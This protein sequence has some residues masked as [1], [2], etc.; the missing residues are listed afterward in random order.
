MNP[1]ITT[2]CSIEENQAMVGTDVVFEQTLSDETDFLKALYKDLRV[3]YP[4]FY[5]MDNLSKLGFL[6]VELLK[7]KRPELM[8]KS[9]DAIAMVFQNQMSC[10]ESDVMHQEQVNRQSPSPAVFVYTLP[11]I[12]IGELSIRNK[13]YGESAFFIGKSRETD[14]LISY[15]KSLILTGK[16]EV[17]LVGNIESFGGEHKLRVVVVERE[18]HGEEFTAENLSRFLENKR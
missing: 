4:K 18:G 8:E 15:S 13:W 11:N 12:V 9:D 16:A 5:K 3:D 7:T 10:L 1:V 14:N 17:C 6:G 2:Y